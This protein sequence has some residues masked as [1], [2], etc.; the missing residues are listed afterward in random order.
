ME[1]STHQ[2]EK[3]MQPLSSNQKT[4]W[5]AYQLAP[6][7]SAYNVYTTTRI[8][9]KVDFRVWQDSWQALVE[10]HPT[11]RATYQLKDTQVF[12]VL[13]TSLSIEID[14]QYVDVSQFEEKEIQQK[15]LEAANHPFDLENS[16][17]FRIYLFEQSSQEYIQ[18]VVIHEILG[19]L[20]SLLI[21]LSEFFD[22]YAKSSVKNCLLV[23]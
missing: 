1:C 14:L 11:L 12:Q 9:G 22:L 6:K 17:A 10:K 4:L 2:S 19:E 16:P 21:L 15:I 3:F 18:L 13:D 8:S 20:R 5:L 7:S 23:S